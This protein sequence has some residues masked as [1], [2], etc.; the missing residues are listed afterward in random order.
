MMPEY[1]PPVNQ[2]NIIQPVIVQSSY[3]QHNNI[4]VRQEREEKKVFW[5]IIAHYLS[6]FFNR[7]PSPNK[8]MPSSSPFP[9]YSIINVFLSS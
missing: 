2:I 9:L 8:L 1:I 3:D 6:I 5:C 4:N 7:N